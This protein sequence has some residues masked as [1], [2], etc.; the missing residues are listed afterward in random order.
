MRRFAVEAVDRMMASLTC[1][2]DLCTGPIYL[3][4]TSHVASISIAAH[5]VESPAVATRLEAHI[6]TLHHTVLLQAAKH[7]KLPELPAS[8]PLAVPLSHPP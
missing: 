7:C 6:N 5:I 1:P 4:T 8:P 3:R 2:R